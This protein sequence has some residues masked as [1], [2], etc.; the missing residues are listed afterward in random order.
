MKVLKKVSE[1][2][3][4]SES[5]VAFHTHALPSPSPAQASIVRSKKDTVHTKAER[6]ILESVKV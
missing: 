5:S 2:D 4:S 3:M 1:R 6:Q